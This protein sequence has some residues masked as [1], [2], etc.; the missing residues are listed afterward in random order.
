LVRAL[1]ILLYTSSL[2]VYSQSVLDTKLDGPVKGTKLTVFLKGFERQHAVR[3]YFVEDWISPFSIEGNYAGQTLGG[4]LRDVLRESTISFIA[5]HEY[6]VVF[7]R[8][9]TYEMERR[10]ALQEAERKQRKIDRIVVGSEEKFNPGRKVNLHGKI[11]HEDTKA[12]VVGATIYAGAVYGGTT[13]NTEGVF[14]L[15]IQTGEH[16][17]TIGF[18]G[19][20]EKVI[21]LTMYEEGSLEIFMQEEPVLLQEVVV[22]SQSISELTNSRA[23]QL[24]LSVGAMKKQPT[25][26]GEADLVRQLQTLPGVNTT[27]EA[28]AG[29]NVRGGSV[30]QNLVLY[31][32]MPLFNTSHSLGFF[33]AFYSEA[34][35]EMTFYRGGIPAEYGGR[36]SSVLDIRS[37]GGDL[38][39]WRG[40]GG[41]GIIS[42]NLMV[43][44]PLKKNKTTMAAS[45]RTT[46]A[47]WF[48][49]ALSTSYH[50]LQNSEVNFY[51]AELR[52]DHSF[53][54]R[55]KLS[56]SYYRSNDKLRVRG[57]TTYQ[58]SNQL[59]S[60]RLDQIFSKRLSGSFQL[61][62]GNYQYFVTDRLPERAFELSYKIT[63]PALK[64][65][66]QYIAGSHRF[67]FGVQSMYYD[68]NPGKLKPTSEIS[69][70]RPVTMDSQ[71]ALESG[72]YVSDIFSP[73]NRFVVEGG[74]RL[75]S[76]LTMGPATVNVY[77]PATPVS[78]PNLVDSVRYGPGGI[79]SSF[80]GV[81]PRFAVRYSLN[82]KSSLKLSFHRIYQYL[83]LISNTTA[84]TPVDIWQP[85]NT[86][87][88]PQRADQASFGYFRDFKE[89]KY[90][91]FAEVF[92]KEMNN[93]LDFRD[94]ANLI[95]NKTLEA[96]L[97]QGDGKAYGIE[98]YVSKNL[99]RLTWAFSY[100]YS[101][102]LRTIRGP[103]SG[104]S[105]NG[106]ME[107]PSSFDQPHMLNASWNY[108]LSRRFSFT[109]NFSFRTGRPVTVP[110]FGFVM[111]G[112]TVAYFSG[113]NQFR[114]PDYHRLDVALVIE[115]NH[116]LKKPWSGSWVIS[117]LN[118][119]GRRN[120]YS[121]FFGSDVPGR[122]NTYQLS[123]L[124]TIIPS[125][126]YSFKF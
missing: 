111:D 126:T 106:G 81:E 56:F 76:F 122:I 65:D 69:S 97:L 27:G 31:D 62:L 89:K 39:K 118:V 74:V 110:I 96:D 125:V 120:A 40:N 5:I 53:N 23:G 82:D 48:I 45:V 13:T 41:I 8:D 58:W 92:Y 14:D 34:I 84:V 18:V 51:D 60:L 101:R 47:N 59:A 24:Q 52:L 17:L 46:Y 11:T 87:F 90:E 124:G 78:L 115:G 68:F 54:D 93:V 70:T 104:E 9:P 16:V 12:P 67:G 73:G 100:T 79:T 116:K 30:D 121:Y 10:T 80:L 44:G 22:N 94:G 36:G 20:K 99:G 72:I 2:T 61:G 114:I 85:S 66:M 26:L 83:H 88:K 105:I 3:F 50:D 33:S 6:G 7:V 32:G 86:F 123:I 102:S 112:Y 117:F 15:S 38:E 98:L 113:R 95:L 28:A 25:L 109:G 57:D 42:T 49:N 107:F 1:L 37:K 35:R 77:L 55:S 103:T 63:Y 43:R 19:L 91:A 75:S 64:A 4:M 71:Q 108:R 119:Y 29:F 21:D